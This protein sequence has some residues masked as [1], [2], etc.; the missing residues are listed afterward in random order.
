MTTTETLCFSELFTFVLLII[1]WFKQIL[2]VHLTVKNYQKKKKK[3]TDS[4]TTKKKKKLAIT[5]KLSNQT[6]ALSIEDILC[7]W[8]VVKSMKMLTS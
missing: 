4:L 6:N 5:E 7:K 2:L 8:S 3:K 1:Y